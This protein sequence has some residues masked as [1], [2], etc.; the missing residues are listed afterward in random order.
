M[1]VAW[2]IIDPLFEKFGSRVQLTSWYRDNS[3]NHVKGGAV[4][5]RCSNKPDFGFTAE[6]AAYIRDNLP[7]NKLLLE[8]NDQ[9]GIHVHVESAK[10]G[11]N[12]GGIVLT[13]ADPKCQ[14]TQ[15]GLQLSF[16]VAAL[17][18]RTA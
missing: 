17:Q 8:K 18:G 10:P 4:D 9:G 7:Y 15:Q 11:Q 12:G 2:T 3:A 13:C 5:L 14:S 16:A 1:N 6:I